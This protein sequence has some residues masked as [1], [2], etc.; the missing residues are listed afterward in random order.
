MYVYIRRREK[1]SVLQYIVVFSANI[2]FFS[3]THYIFTLLL[4]S[5]IIL[6]SPVSED[7]NLAHA[8]QLAVSSGQSIRRVNNGRTHARMAGK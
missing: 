2:I 3:N 6:S 8:I 5:T 1:T 4:L 7:A